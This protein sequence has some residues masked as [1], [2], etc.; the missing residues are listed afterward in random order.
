MSSVRVRTIKGSPERSAS[1]TWDEIARMVQETLVPAASID[2][3]DVSVALG[4][5]A[6]VGRTL[7]AT[8]VLADEPV[9]LTAPPLHVEIYVSLGNDALK[10]EERLGK[11]PGAGTASEWKL[12]VPDPVPYSAQV[13][14]AVAQHDALYAGAAPTPVVGAAAT[15]TAVSVDADALRRISGSH[16][17]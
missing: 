9:V 4:H 6:G 16:H 14:S 8:G 3:D 17:S 12:Y 10:G 15:Q 1:A 7:I 5:L 11:V 2:D 13:A